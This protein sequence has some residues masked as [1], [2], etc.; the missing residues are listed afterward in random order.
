MAALKNMMQMQ[1]LRVQAEQQ[2][3]QSGQIENEMKQRQLADQK[4]MTSAMQ[5]W[6]GKDPSELPGLVLKHGGSGQSVL[7]LKSGILDYQQKQANLTKDQQVAAK[8][9]NDFIAGQLDA[10]KNAKPEEQPAL[11]EQAKQAIIN[12]PGVDQAT[13]DGFAQLQYHSPVQIETLEKI[14]MGKSA[15]D[16]AAFKQSETGKNVAQ[17]HEAEAATQKTQAETAWYQKYGIPPGVSTETMGMADWLQK[18]P[19]KGPADYQRYIK[20]LPINTR[21]SLESGA[22]VPGGPGSGQPAAPGAVAQRFGMTQEAFDQAAEKYYT[23]GQLPPL[24]RGISGVALNRALMNRSG[25]LHPGA[26]LAANSAEYEANKKSL[27]KLQSNTDAVEAFEKTAGKNLDLFLQQAKGVIDSGSPFINRP[28]RLVSK[29]LLGSGEV[30][31]Y[32][33]A[34][35]VAINEIAKVTGNPGLS[36]QLS[37]TARKE[38]ADFN[39]A[40]A[41]LKQTYDVANIL[42]QDMA[43]R[44]Q[45]YQ[46]QIADIKGRLTGGAQSKQQNPVS[47]TFSWDSMPKHQ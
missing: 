15:L 8:D 5:E 23:T 37:D 18:N 25:E 31:A 39:P 44:R 20:T 47:G 17:Q 33:T 24:G 29:S 6:D 9:A 32:D 14:H 12:H 38:V 43:N 10:V 2:A 40:S 7:S 1:P 42:R 4:A 30:A 13:K 19:G 34:R 41:T 26:S 22:G 46:E 28:L 3:L 16:D 27:D 11:L 36:G 21:Y 45:S 35:Q